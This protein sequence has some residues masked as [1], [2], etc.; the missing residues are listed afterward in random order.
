MLL[1][2]ILLLMFTVVVSDCVV[3]DTIDFNAAV[4]VAIGIFPTIFLLLPHICHNDVVAA[5]VLCIMLLLL[6][7]CCFYYSFYSLPVEVRLHLYT[8]PAVLLPSCT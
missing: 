1:L 4:A 2:L 3:N 7:W 8:S 5:I 6:V